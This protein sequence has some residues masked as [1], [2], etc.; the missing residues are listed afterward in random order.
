[1]ITSTLRLATHWSATRNRQWYPGKHKLWYIVLTEIE[2]NLYACVAIFTCQFALVK[3]LFIRSRNGKFY[4]L[5]LKFNPCIGYVRPTIYIYRSEYLGTK[6][7]QRLDLKVR[8]YY[9]T[10]R[11][12]LSA[13]TLRHFLHACVFSFRSQGDNTLY[14]PESQYDIFG[15]PG[16]MLF[17]TRDWE[18]INLKIISW[19]TGSG[20]GAKHINGYSEEE[21]A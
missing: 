8:G 7:Y 4:L 6:R 20:R 9:M 5:N 18:F 16:F 13:L 10:L 21:K 2:Y 11:Q 12:G 14:E 19:N 15:T 3:L 1:M 17:T